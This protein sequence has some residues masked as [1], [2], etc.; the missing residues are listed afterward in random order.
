M[1][2][3]V[4]GAGAIGQVFGHY[5]Q[6]GGNRVTFFARSERAQRIKNGL[7]LYHLNRRNSRRRPIQFDSFDVFS[8]FSGIGDQE[9][10]QVYFCIPSDALSENLLEQ[11]SRSSGEAT[12]IKLQP[13]LGDRRIYMRHFEESHLVSGMISFMSYAAPLPKEKV[14]RPGIAYWLPPLLSSP[15]SG[16]TNRVKAVVKAL[17][18]G[19]LRTRV[20]G[21]VESMVGFA[22]AAQAPLTAGLEHS[23]WSINEYRASPTLEVVCRSIKEA[24]AIVSN[25]LQ[26][27]PPKIMKVLNCSL[28]RLGLSFLPRRYPFN[29]EHYLGAHY[30]KLHEQS[31]KNLDDYIEQGEKMDLPHDSLLELREGLDRL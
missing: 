2:A 12:I 3:L 18:D 14:V 8:E 31:C 21:D 13:G 22:L 1:N 10:D 7:V 19:G 5:L 27:D 26:S 20:H 25:Y 23:H 6:K 9:W 11:V 24:T 15:F 16:S 29:M 4:I 17:N 30:R 28:I